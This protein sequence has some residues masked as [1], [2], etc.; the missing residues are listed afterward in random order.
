MKNEEFRKKFT[1]GE[2]LKIKSIFQKLERLWPWSFNH[3]SS[4]FIL[5]FSF[6]EKILLLWK[7]KSCI[8]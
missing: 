5:N 4:C 8:S 1:K 3:N 6:I 2:F 7:L